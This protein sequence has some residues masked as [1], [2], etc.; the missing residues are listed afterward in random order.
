LL[1]KS[2]SLG[3][4]RRN[5]TTNLSC[6]TKKGTWNDSL[7]MFIYKKMKPILYSSSSLL[8][9]LKVPQPFTSLRSERLKRETS[10]ANNAGKKN[11]EKTI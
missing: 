3:S 1:W 2:A 9:S 6:H 8:T 7:V 10:K 4:L 5:M 11:E